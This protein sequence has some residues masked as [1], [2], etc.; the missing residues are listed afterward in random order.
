MMDEDRDAIFDWM[1]RGGVS[2]KDDIWAETRANEG[3]RHVDI[4]GQSV[5]DSRKNECK[6]PRQGHAWR[7]A[8]ME[9]HFVSCDPEFL[10]ES[11]TLKKKWQI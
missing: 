9:C 2:D 7:V 10:Y 1:I 5:L 8:R 11:A 4:S 3:A 6:R